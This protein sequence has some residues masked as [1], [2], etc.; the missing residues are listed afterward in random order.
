MIKHQTQSQTGLLSASS[1]LKT[2]LARTRSR[3]RRPRQKTPPQK[4][5]I[6]ERIDWKVKWR[7]IQCIVATDRITLISLCE[8]NSSPA[9][10]VSVVSARLVY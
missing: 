1:G 8:T 4:P 7:S 9:P 2:L 5:K 10:A 3:K 6:P